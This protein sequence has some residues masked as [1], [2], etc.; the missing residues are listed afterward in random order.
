MIVTCF[1]GYEA[2]PVCFWF[3][4]GN[5]L[6]M[7]DNSSVLSRA[8]FIDKKIIVAPVD[9]PNALECFFFQKEAFAIG[10]ISSYAHKGGF[11]QGKGEILQGWYRGFTLNERVEYATPM[12]IG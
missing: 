3:R 11:V 12:Q 1:L 6:R 8:V 10:H 5:A 2:F 9:M 7:N 4:N